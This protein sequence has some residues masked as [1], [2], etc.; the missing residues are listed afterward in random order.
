MNSFEIKN[1]V[2]KEEVEQ[3]LEY[4]NQLPESDDY[5]NHQA[6]RKLTGY[7][8]EHMPFL[9]EMFEEKFS[10]Y[11]EN[12]VVSGSNFTNWIETVEL[13]TDGWQPQ[14]DQSNKLGY[15][16]LVPLEVTPTDAKS[17]TIIFDQFLDGPAVT[18]KKFIDDKDWNKSHEYTTPNDERI[19]NKKDNNLITNEY[20][21]EHLSHIQRELLNNFSV[22]NTHQWKIGDAIVWKR[23]HFHTSSSFSDKIKSKLHLLFFINQK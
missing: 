17:Y 1:I 18:M 23:K 15:A 13:H 6:K 10:K 22:S 4:Y 14:E 11:F 8:E 7:H 20:Y 16:V 2:N 12:Y 19:K 5:S 3:I 9:K 21:S